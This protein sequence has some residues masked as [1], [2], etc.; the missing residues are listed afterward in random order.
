MVF[1]ISVTCSFWYYKVENKNPILVAYSWIYKSAL[2]ALTFASLLVS[3]VGILT[4]L[5]ETKRK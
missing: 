1:V 4:L 2:G 5:V 3:A